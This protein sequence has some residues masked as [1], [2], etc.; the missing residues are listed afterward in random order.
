[1]NICITKARRVRGCVVTKISCLALGLLWCGHAPA[2]NPVLTKLHTRTGESADGAN[3]G[4]STAVTDR[5]IV[6]G[7]PNADDRGTNA[8]AAYVY[9]ARN[10]RFV[11]QLLAP[12][13]EAYDF[14]GWKVA[15]CGNVAAVTAIG[16]DDAGDHAGAAY[17]FD[18]RNGRM[19]QK[20]V[21]PAGSDG[22]RFGFS[23]ALSHDLV[24]VG[25]QWPDA[26]QGRALVFEVS[27]GNAVRALNGGDVGAGDNFGQAVALC[28]N[29][30][31]VGAPQINS[32]GAGAVYLFDVT[33]GVEL[34]KVTAT[35][36]VNGDR[37]GHGIAIS[38]GRLVIGAPT[39]SGTGAVYVFDMTR[40][41]GPALTQ[42]AKF[43]PSDSNVSDLVGESVAASDHLCLVS[44]RG[45]DFF[46]Q[47]SGAAYLF[48]LSNGKEL[49]K[50]LVPDG[51]TNDHLGSAVALC[52]NLAVVGADGDDEIEEDQGSAYFVRGLNGA[53]PLLSLA[54]SRD[55]A[56]GTIDAEYAS[57]Q[58]AVISPAGRTTFRARMTGPGSG[59]GRDYGIWSNVGSTFAF[60]LLQRSRADRFGVVGGPG[61]RIGSVFRPI[62]EQDGEAVF[63]ASFVGP[64]INARNNQGVLISDGMTSELIHQTGETDPVVG[65]GQFQRFLENVQTRSPSPAWLVT[66]YQLRKGIDGVTAANDSGILTATMA[67]SGIDGDAREGNPV[68]GA[69]GDFRQFFGRVAASSSDSFGFAAY[70]QPPGEE[71]IQGLFTS[72]GDGTDAGDRVAREGGDEFSGSGATYRSFLGESLTTLGQ[73]I[74]RASLVGTGVNARNNEGLWHNDAVGGDILLVREGQE[75]DPVNEP[76]VV[77]NRLLG[78]WPVSLH[79]AV[80]WVKL[81]GPGVRGANDCALY[82]I[83]EHP[84]EGAKL[85][86]L[87]REGDPVCDWDCPRVRTIQRVDVNPDSVSGRYVIV[88]A[89]T[90]APS[91]NQAM[92]T[93][94]AFLGD[95]V[96]KQ[97]LK[98]PHLQFR[99]GTAY[100]APG[101]ETTSIRSLVL[102][103]RIDRTGAGGKGLGQTIT[104]NGRLMICVQ[105][106]NRAKELMMGIP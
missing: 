105:F 40:R 54:K 66:A 88:A 24:V 80:V 8:G 22:H 82:A 85:I 103:P 9:D 21:D 94:N 36:G 77:I 25:S 49:Q 29:I 15:V 68:A 39:N 37:F 18:L 76:G 46:G 81:R 20:L 57:F 60:K 33:T 59:G 61:V 58:E 91:R 96:T 3:F 79:E 90:G 28:G 13:G 52:G 69:S 70:Y 86:K 38:A 7:E 97:T 98:L 87:M 34:E 64:G 4:A 10:G 84:T 19:L 106:N 45:D 101:G 17:L 43:L 67:S 102:T 30:A 23:V 78:F 89:L 12:D 2:F 72:L 47:T 50:V 55:F 11:R 26:F 65:G 63:E 95:A 14:L 35:D 74:F 44:A 51:R 93:G 75:P 53:L 6:V 1:M 56:T 92:F 99:K 16:D 104:G 73:P 71:P 32:S 31:A 62:Q 83:Q 27:T 48:D 42:S 100:Q 41:T 5:W